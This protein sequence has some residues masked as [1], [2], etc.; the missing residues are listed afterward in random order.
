MR[1]SAKF[2]RGGPGGK[3]CWNMHKDKGA[4]VM[5]ADAV[6]TATAATGAET[7]DPEAIIEAIAA[8]VTGAAD[9]SF[10]PRMFLS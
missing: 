1:I 8:E 9:A 4:R 3:I 7:V 6:E 2:K 5:A 10:L